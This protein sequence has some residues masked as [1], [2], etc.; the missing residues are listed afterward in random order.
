MRFWIDCLSAEVYHHQSWK[1]RVG[2]RQRKTISADLKLAQA[3]DRVALLHIIGSA[4][5]LFM[6]LYMSSCERDNAG[7]FSTGEI[8]GK[9]TEICWLCGSV[10][11]ARVQ[12][13][14]ECGTIHT[15]RQ[16]LKNTFGHSFDPHMSLP[17][18]AIWALGPPLANTQPRLAYSLILFCMSQFS[19][20]EIVLCFK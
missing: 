14:P 15:L 8:I 11:Y 9:R 20:Q 19:T 7:L 16:L 2:R 10:G 17:S 3:V 6:H 13:Y 12:N 5:M 18:G 4:L 1:E